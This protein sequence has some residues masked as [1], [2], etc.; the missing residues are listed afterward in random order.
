MMPIGQED[1]FT[2][3]F[4]ARSLASF[5][6]FDNCASTK[7]PPNTKPTPTHCIGLRRWP[8]QTT[9]KIMVSIFLVTV[10]VTKRSEPKVERV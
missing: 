2:S 8:N 7:T 1:F 4:F 10:T 6:C 3:S 5:S 9:D